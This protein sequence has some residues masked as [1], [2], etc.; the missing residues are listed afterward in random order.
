MYAS[1]GVAK[2]TGAM[3]VKVNSVGRGRI[4]GLYPGAHYRP[5]ASARQSGGERAYTLGPERW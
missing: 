5:I 2:P 3:K 4:P 1:H